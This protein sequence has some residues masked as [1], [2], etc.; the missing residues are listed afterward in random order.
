MKGSKQMKA[1]ILFLFL[2]AQCI[3]ST[4]LFEINLSLDNDK[5]NLSSNS[6]WIGENIL[7]TNGLISLNCELPKFSSENNTWIC[8]IKLLPNFRLVY[9]DIVC[10]TITNC[11]A[12]Y[13]VNA[14]PSGDENWDFMQV[15][16]KRIDDGSVSHS[17]IGKIDHVLK[18]HIFVD[19]LCR[20]LIC[21][22]IIMLTRLLYKTIM[23]HF[24]ICNYYYIDMSII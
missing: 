9:L 11:K 3:I 17:Y 20:I 6:T 5:N 14:I 21:V 19:I 16:S 1:A 18:M 10:D 24:N 23:S 4:Q 2:T 7:D 13:V 15:I 8:K 12:E 22:I